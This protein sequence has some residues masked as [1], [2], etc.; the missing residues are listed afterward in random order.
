MSSKYRVA[1]LITAYENIDSV[2]TCINSLDQQSYSV[3]K[4]LI[5]DNS[6]HAPIQSVIPSL[7]HKMGY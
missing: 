6:E 2:L 7:Y 4:I 3:E 5:V 1:A